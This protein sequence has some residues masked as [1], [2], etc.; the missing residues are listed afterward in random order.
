MARKPKKIITRLDFHRMCPLRPAAYR[1]HLASEIA[2][3]GQ[4][5]RAG[6]HAV[7]GEPVAY[8]RLLARCIT[9]SQRASV[10]SRHADLAAAHAIFTEAGVV[11]DE[12]EARLLAYQPHAQIAE[13][14]KVPVGVV[15]KYAEV[16]FQIP[17]QDTGIDGF[18]GSVLRMH[19]WLHRDPT[20]GEVWRTLGLF[21]GRFLVDVLV[22]DFFNRPCNDPKQC[23]RQAEQGRF[24]VKEQA[25]IR[26]SVVPDGLW[27]AEFRRLFG[28]LIDGPPK[29]RDELMLRA[30]FDLLEGF[31]RGSLRAKQAD[32]TSVRGVAEVPG[33]VATG[34]QH[35]SVARDDP[36]RPTCHTKETPVTVPKR[37][38]ELLPLAPQ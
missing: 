21:G 24:L 25:L 31:A 10:R 14:V 2:R 22:D 30:H 29:D 23:R 7:I 18:L 26:R 12:L 5:L 6:E 4:R 37:A 13:Q 8:L 36:R 9:V 28:H 3:P 17:P 38:D 16:F 1:W 34:T 35:P 33:N 20:E 15:T 11:R 19:E 27:L 32:A